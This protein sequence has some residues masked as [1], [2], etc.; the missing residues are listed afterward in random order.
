VSLA[1]PGEPRLPPAPAMRQPDSSWAPPGN[2]GAPI[3][4]GIQ[5]DVPPGRIRT[6]TSRLDEAFLPNLSVIWSGT[7]NRPGLV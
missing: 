1:D 4:D 7:A 5:G 6:V 2:A 3:S